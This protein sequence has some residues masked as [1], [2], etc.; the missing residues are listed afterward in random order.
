MGMAL[1]GLREKKTVQKLSEEERIFWNDILK[2]SIKELK[3]IS[4][5]LYERE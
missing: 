2:K 3:L 1:K 5:I 4:K